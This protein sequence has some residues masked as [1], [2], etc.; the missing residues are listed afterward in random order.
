MAPDT[1]VNFG[2]LLGDLI[3]DSNGNNYLEW[4]RVLD[5][6]LHMIKKEY[7]IRAELLTPPRVNAS[8]E[9]KII[10]ASLKADYDAVRQMMLL[11]MDSY[12]NYAFEFST[13][14]EMIVTLNKWCMNWLKA[15]RQQ[16][17]RVLHECKMEMNGCM[18]DHVVT[19][20]D[21][22]S[23]LRPRS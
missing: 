10:Y 15:K 3:L 16:L 23:Q 6:N 17:T 21:Y 8:E 14:Y 18:R 5:D 7:L 20:V 12:L 9:E 4:L 13:I 11:H 22:I 1:A 2:A 19:M